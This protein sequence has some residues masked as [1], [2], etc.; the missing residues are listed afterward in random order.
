MQAQE[1]IVEQNIGIKQLGQNIENAAQTTGWNRHIA[2]FLFNINRHQRLVRHGI[3]LRAVEV[4]ALQKA[5]DD[6]QQGN[7]ATIQLH[8]VAEVE[9]V[10][11]LIIIVVRHQHAEPVIGSRVDHLN[12]ERIVTLHPPSTALQLRPVIAQKFSPTFFAL[13][14]VRSVKRAAFLERRIEFL[15]IEDFLKRQ[16]PQRG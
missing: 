4:A 12:A 14:R 9:P 6:W 8:A 15:R 1:A 7:L 3:D 10:D 16:Q 5:Y 13:Q 2:A 11:T